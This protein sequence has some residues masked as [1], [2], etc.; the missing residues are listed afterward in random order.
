MTTTAIKPMQAQ[1]SNAPMFIKPDDQVSM[2]KVWT[3]GFDKLTKTQAFNLTPEERDFGVSLITGLVNKCTKEKTDIK[4]LDLTN[5][6]EQTKHFAKLKL[7]FQDGEIYID[8][9]NNKDT[10]K[11]DVR[12]MKQYQG[13]RKLAARWIRPDMKIVDWKDGVVCDGDTY[14]YEYDYMTGT[15]ILKYKANPN[16]NHDDLTKITHAF[17]IAYI[18]IDGKPRVPY[19]CVIDKSRIMKAFNASAAKD[20]GPWSNHTA[21]MVRKT[22]YWC[23]YNDILAPFIDIP[24][25]LQTSFAATEDEMDFA[26][27]DTQEPADDNVYDIPTEE[28]TSDFVIEPENEQEQEQSFMDYLD[29][30]DAKEQAEVQEVFYSEYKNNKEKYHLVEGSYDAVKKTVKV[31]LK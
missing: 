4:L 14:S 25:D 16:V 29:E 10:G 17:A 23:L 24:S 2:I 21:R 19:I 6:F 15:S 22:A 5:F 7:S 8:V 31:T 30:Q 20:K 26:N 3:E 11:K 18:E 13:I 9:R 1:G 28:N 27:S 12:V